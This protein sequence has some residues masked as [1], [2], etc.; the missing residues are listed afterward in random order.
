MDWQQ[1]VHVEYTELISIN[2]NLL[3][4]DV[5]YHYPVVLRQNDDHTAEIELTIAYLAGSTLHRE[6]WHARRAWAEVSP[7]LGITE[8]KLTDAR[9]IPL[10]RPSGLIITL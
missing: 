10:D 9:R 2:G 1:S 6:R 8:Y 7:H 5:S 4:H 3:P